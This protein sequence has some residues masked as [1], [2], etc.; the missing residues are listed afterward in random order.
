M[1][2]TKLADTVIVI[3][4]L[5]PELDFP[6]LLLAIRKLCNN[7]ILIVN[8]GSRLACTAV[9]EKAAAVENCEV[10][11]HG[12]NLGKGRALKTAFRHCLNKYPALKGVVTADA[13]GQHRP[14]DI[15][16]CLE[17]M[18]ENP[19]SLVL[20]CRD[21]NLENVPWRSRF[22][23]KLTMGFFRWFL[24]L[25]I[26]DTQTGLR[27]I[28]AAFMKIL[29]EKPGERFEFETIMLL[30]SRNDR[31]SQIFP[32]KEYTIETV[33]VND[34]RET[35]FRPI[36]DS[37]KIYRIIFNHLFGRLFCFLISGILSAVLDQGLFALLFYKLLPAIGLPPLIFAVVISRTASL[38]F[39]YTLNRNVV[40]R[41]K[42][43]IFDTSSFGGY[44]T[45]C[46]FIMFSSYGLVKL[47]TLLYS[48]A[49]VLISKIVV[50]SM[51]FFVSYKL[52]KKIIFKR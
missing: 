6:N 27:G 13:D 14:E 11:S 49:N 52:Q 40:F 30:E 19:D 3:P 47:S 17:V 38:L 16:R 42:K 41:G 7:P 5:N 39:N 46:A 26:S 8:D 9:F 43:G 24:R 2:V 34:N 33:Y 48:G 44:L 12:A 51:L 32:I 18:R 21:F 35:H 1:G 37:L 36:I 29:L 22:G 45:L 20:G 28:P 15:V 23:N 50:D 25:K 10:L 31:N 4:S